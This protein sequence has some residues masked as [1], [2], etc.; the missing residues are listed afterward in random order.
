MMASKF[1]QDDLDAAC[2]TPVEHGWPEDGIGETSEAS[3]DS[4]SDDDDDD[5]ELTPIEYA[6]R[7]GLIQDY[8]S[9]DPFRTVDSL[10]PHED[11]CTD[12]SI[13]TLC[14]DSDMLTGA[15]YA[16]N[17]SLHEKWDINKDTAHFLASVLS[18]GRDEGVEALHELDA[19]LKLRSLKLEDAVLPSDHE[20]DI[21]RLRWRNRV[22]LC[23]ESMDP[24]VLAASK[25][26]GLDW[27]DE[28]LNLRII[29]IE[30]TENEK[31][32]VD[33]ETMQYIRGV[34]EL[35]SFDNDEVMRTALHCEA[36]SI[37]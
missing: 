28:E 26:E 20:I 32:E 33:V 3:S 31:L 5:D 34:M 13:D 7:Y 37:A 9:Q 24:M 22:E 36:V 29:V 15:S 11:A 27:S 2:L 19:L 21:L 23:S 6:W 12:N 35:V 18:F 17:P 8:L 10:W 16:K 14:V 25:G 4:E 1:S 30:C